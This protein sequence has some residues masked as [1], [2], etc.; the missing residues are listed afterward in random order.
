MIFDRMAPNYGPRQDFGMRH[1]DVREPGMDFGGGMGRERF[2]IGGGMLGGQFRFGGN[3]PAMGV[4]GP[5]M[6]VGL[7]PQQVRGPQMGGPMP[8]Y[9]QPQFQAPPMQQG[10]YGQQMPMN[11]LMALWG[12][13]MGGYR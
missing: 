9:Q 4:Q 1:Q 10:G 5:Q 2:D 8:T 12:R 6:S 7:P 3:T 11:S 13:R